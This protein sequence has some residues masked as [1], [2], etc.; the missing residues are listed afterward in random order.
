MLMIDC[1]SLQVLRA[2]W[3]EC[4]ATPSG[5]GVRL[6]KG[7]GGTVL[8]GMRRAHCVE[9]ISPLRVFIEGFEGQVYLV[10]GHKL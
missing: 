10:I 8:S 5:W 7:Y 4:V 3:E 9:F 2:S 6:K 1:F